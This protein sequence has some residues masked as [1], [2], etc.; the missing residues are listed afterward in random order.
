MVE[1]FGHGQSR[2]CK[3]DFILVSVY[4][5]N[6]SGMRCQ[7]ESYQ[8]LPPDSLLMNIS[9]LQPGRGQRLKSA[10]WYLPTMIA[11]VILIPGVNT[12]LSAR[13]MICELSSVLKSSY[14]PARI[15]LYPGPFSN[16]AMITAS[17]FC[18]GGEMSITSTLLQQ[19]STYPPI[20]FGRY[21]DDL[22]HCIFKPYRFLD[23]CV[24]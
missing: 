2:P 18:G 4:D 14:S 10:E 5:F 13:E 16:W 17:S 8:V 3:F 9:D 7:H 12:S 19:V 15:F 1:A 21:W 6:L 20:V 23:P 22:A 24:S 11:I